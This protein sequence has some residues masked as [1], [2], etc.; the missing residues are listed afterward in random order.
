MRSTK[1]PSIL[2]VWPRSITESPSANAY[3]RPLGLARGFDVHMLLP[4]DADL[5][6]EIES[7]VTR[8]DLPA[9]PAG[10]PGR[11][12]TAFLARTVESAGEIHRRVGLSCVY[13]S[14]DIMPVLA[15]WMTRRRLGIPWVANGWDHPYGRHAER[16]DCVGRLGLWLRWAM[17]GALLRSADLLVLHILPPV[18]RP[19]GLPA[20][21]IFALPNGAANDRIQRAAKGVL[22]RRGLVG[23]VANVD[24][25]KGSDILLRAVARARKEAPDLRL[26]LVGEVTEAFRPELARLLCELDLQDA[27][28]VTD[29]VPFHDAMRLAAECTVL[30]YC[31]R[32]LPRFHWSYPLK[33]G[34]AFALGRPIVAADMPGARAYL[35]DE[36]AG[37]LFPPNDEVALADVLKHLLLNPA[38][39]E[40]MGREGR[41][42]AQSLDWNRLA[43]RLNERLM[44]LLKER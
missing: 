40:S 18:M 35:A 39:C 2:Y 8:H 27:V 26:R 6:G 19:L 25:P 44:R 20:S 17:D 33:V 4:K 5:P 24:F 22:P 43:D 15:G 36:R 28:E 41:Q 38:L 9:T 16:L 21:K 13:T 23:A 3:Q 14:T 1:A 42:R 12:E 34:E 29:W 30:G 37:L 10:F 11:R 31:Y 7:V 32:D